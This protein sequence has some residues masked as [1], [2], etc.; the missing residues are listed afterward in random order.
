M[1]WGLT[2]NVIVLK[3]CLIICTGVGPNIEHIL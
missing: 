3:M 1:Y 2:I